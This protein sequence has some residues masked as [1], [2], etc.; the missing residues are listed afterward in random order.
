MSIFNRRPLPAPFCLREL[1]MLSE[2]PNRAP[3]AERSLRT[4]PS[5]LIAVDFGV[6]VANSSLPAAT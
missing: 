1:P 5:A 4:A 6:T 3:P 2:W